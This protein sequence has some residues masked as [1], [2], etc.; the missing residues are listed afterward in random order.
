MS[1]RKAVLDVLAE[2]GGL[3]YCE[4]ALNGRTVVPPS[5]RSFGSRPRED[6]PT[7]QSLTYLLGHNDNEM[8]G[9]LLKQKKKQSPNS[10][11]ACL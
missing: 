6:E 8:G 2:D 3:I 4:V 5:R 11:R 1:K 10:T 9:S 7:R